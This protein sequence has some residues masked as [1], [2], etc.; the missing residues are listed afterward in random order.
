MDRVAYINHDIDDAV[1][2]GRARRSTI[3]PPSPIEILGDTGP[4]RIDTLVHDLVEHSEQAGDIV[5]GELVG[6]GDGRAAR[7]HVR[8]R[9]PR[10]RGHAASTRRSSASSASLFDHYCAH[11]EAIPASIP[12]GELARRVT[13]YIAG[14]TDRY[15]IRAFE[16]L[17]VPVAFALVSPLHGRLPRSRARRGRHG[18]A[19]LGP[20]RAA[21]RR[22]QQL[23]RPLPVPRR[24]HAVVP[25][26][27]RREALLLLRLPGL[28]RSVHVRDG[29][30]GTRLQGRARVARRPLRR[31]ARDRGRGPGGG[32]APRAARAP[33]VAARPR[34]AY[35]ARYLWDSAEAAPARDTCAAAASRSETLREFRVGYAPSAWDRILLRLA[36]GGLQRRGAARGRARAALEDQPR[37]GLRPLPR[38]DHVPGDRRPRPRAR[39]RRARDARQPAAEVPEHRRRRALPQAQRPVRDRP[40]ARRRRARQRA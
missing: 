33:A 11:P 28:R 40:R 2:A 14:M 19:R 31:P 39:V 23:L 13:D 8:A 18:R 5:Q 27:P 9:L 37:A 3:C 32:V 16:E 7:L 22:R 10:A 1:R 20:H 21:P 30:R 35:Y 38:A 6:G 34:R 26:Q 17:S 29:D 4:R 24:A 36:T 12:D 15:C 25:R